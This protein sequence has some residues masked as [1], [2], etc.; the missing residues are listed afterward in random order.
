M[1]SILD[2]LKK[3]EAES[4]DPSGSITWHP[5]GSTR[6]SHPKNKIS[7]RMVPASLILFGFALVLLLYVYIDPS[8]LGRTGQNPTSSSQST[9]ALPARKAGISIDQTGSNEQTHMPMVPPD[10]KSIGK[11][12]FAPTPAEKADTPSTVTPALPSDRLQPK[13]VDPPVFRPEPSSPEEPVK[14]DRSDPIRTAARKPPVPRTLDRHL[15]RRTGTASTPLKTGASGAQPKVI[16]ITA[17][18]YRGDPPL[19]VQAIAWSAH[20]AERLVV[21][22]D[23]IAREGQKIGDLQILH[24]Q[25]EEIIILKGSKQWALKFRQP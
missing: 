16:K 6:S 19:K 25:P 13:A 14:T 20:P 11:T 22:N 8:W 12:P 4:H 2:A 21:I 10:K 3:V 18:P 15:T 1:S 7:R 17:K 5:A 9:A 24:I 23:I